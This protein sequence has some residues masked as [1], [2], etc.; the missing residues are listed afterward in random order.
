MENC[1]KYSALVD[2]KTGI[3]CDLQGEFIDH[4]SVL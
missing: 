4:V 3:S 2:L 1:S